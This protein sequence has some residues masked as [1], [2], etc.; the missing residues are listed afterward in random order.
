MVKRGGEQEAFH[1]LATLLQH[2]TQP[3]ARPWHWGALLE[4]RERC[5]DL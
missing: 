3:E 5:M 1:K 2:E 4:R